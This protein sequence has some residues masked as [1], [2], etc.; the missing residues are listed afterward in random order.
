LGAAV[1][2]R[3][4]NRHRALP[5]FAVHNWPVTADIIDPELIL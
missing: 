5:L 2:E 3:L 1:E 4:R